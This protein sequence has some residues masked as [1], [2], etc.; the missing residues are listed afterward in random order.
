M[1]LL[2]QFNN[3]NSKATTNNLFIGVFEIQSYLFIDPPDELTN[4]FGF[5]LNLLN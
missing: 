5:N 3:G 4:R 2:I 1:I